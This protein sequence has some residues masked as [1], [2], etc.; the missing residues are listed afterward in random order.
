MDRDQRTR[1]PNSDRITSPSRLP[2][3]VSTNTRSANTKLIKFVLNLRYDTFILAPGDIAGEIG[4]NFESSEQ[5]MQG[6]AGRVLPF[7]ILLCNNCIC[8]L[9]EGCKNTR[10]V[11]EGWESL[12][13]PISRAQAARA[14]VSNYLSCQQVP[15][16]LSLYLSLHP[17]L[18]RD[19][20]ERSSSHL[21]V[22]FS[23]SQ[24]NGCIVRR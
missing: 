14:G 4:V 21:L 3:Q 2:H 1:G 13:K 19:Y 9:G 17:L 11:L 23:Q 18:C 20:L 8:D 24:I 12:E 5:Q 10:Q 16:L 6:P 15:S 22:R 7:Y